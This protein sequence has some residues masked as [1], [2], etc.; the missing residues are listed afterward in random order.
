MAGTID[1]FYGIISRY[2]YRASSQME[3]LECAALNHR[4]TEPQRFTERADRIGTA[5]EHR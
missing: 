4:G 1:F 5:D 2:S 3:R